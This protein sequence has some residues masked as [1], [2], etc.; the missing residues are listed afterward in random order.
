MKILL[1]EDNAIDTDLIRRSLPVELPACEIHA[2][3]SLA[4][5]R[6]ALNQAGPF[7]IALLDVKIPDGNGLEILTEI[8]GSGVDMVVILLTGTGDE[9]LGGF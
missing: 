1:L 5:A 4:S 8:R 7:D 6:Q 3:T 2:V 9:D